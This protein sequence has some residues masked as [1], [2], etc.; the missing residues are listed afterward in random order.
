MSTDRSSMQAKRLLYH[1]LQIGFQNSGY[2]WNSDNTAE[3]NEIVDSIIDACAQSTPVAPSTQSTPSTPSTPTQPDAQSDWIELR[4]GGWVR[5]SD[6]YRIHVARNGDL[7]AYLRSQDD[8]LVI[9]ADD[10][11]LGDFLHAVGIYTD[12]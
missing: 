1:Y 9:D 12:R 4:N 8:G 2:R 11:G 5:A 10:P 6:V 3:V 7:I